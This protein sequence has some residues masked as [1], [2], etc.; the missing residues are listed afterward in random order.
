MAIINLTEDERREYVRD[1]RRITRQIV[2]DGWP[3]IRRI[4]AALLERGR[5]HGR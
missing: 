2:A 1:L 4:A 5:S 3:A